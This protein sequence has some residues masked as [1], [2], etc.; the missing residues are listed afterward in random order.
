MDDFEHYRCRHIYMKQCDEK[1]K[2]AEAACHKVAGIE[3]IILATPVDI[4]NIHLIYSLDHFSFE[5][6]IELFDELG[7]DCDESILLSLRNAIYQYLEENAREN[8]DFDITRFD[9]KSPKNQK[10]PP[11]SP[12]K[13]W[14]DY[15]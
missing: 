9:H 1:S 4:L 5:L 3:G 8:L 2:Q 15:H 7:F 10:I 14:E 13:Y 11:Q 6:I 12:D